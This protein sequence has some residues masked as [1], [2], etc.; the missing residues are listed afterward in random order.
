M[1]N[2]K[3]N[4]YSYSSTKVSHAQYWENQHKISTTAIICLPKC[5]GLNQNALGSL[6]INNFKEFTISNSSTTYIP[7]PITCQRFKK[8]AK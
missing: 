3:S 6:S 8:M 2:S 4:N 1:C 5:V 7:Y